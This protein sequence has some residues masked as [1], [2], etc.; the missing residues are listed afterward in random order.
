M[1][2]RS[3][4]GRDL[5]S[6]S[7]HHSRSVHGDSVHT[8]SS[9]HGSVAALSAGLV[10]G[11]GGELDRSVHNAHDK[12]DV[13]LDM[14][15]DIVMPHHGAGGAGGGGFGLQVVT[16]GHGFETSSPRSV[17]VSTHTT[18][19]STWQSPI[20]PIVE[21]I[22]GEESDCDDGPYRRS[23]GRDV[24]KSPLERLRERTALASTSTHS[25]VSAGSSSRG[26]L[27]DADS[28]DRPF[29]M[30]SPGSKRVSFS[31]DEDA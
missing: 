16:S 13:G 18:P 22:A 19:R 3:A 8:R 23:A 15:G 29:I 4:S 27:Q 17:S 6:R 26:D 14:D 12:S 9:S 2:A 28:D 7:S 20:E 10:S 21:S 11:V 5:L 30:L 31:G 1:L 24:G 25:K